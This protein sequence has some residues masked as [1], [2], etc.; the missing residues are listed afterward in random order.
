MDALDETVECRAENAE[1]VV[2]HNAQAFGQVAF[3]V[4]NVGHGA[5]HDVQRLDQQ[6]NQHAQ[7][8]DDYR[9]RNNGRNDCRGAELAELREGFVF[10]HRKP[11]VPVDRRQAFDGGE[12]DDAGFAI[13]LGFTEFAADAGG[14]VR[15][16][17][18]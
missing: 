17:L 12:R 18:G 3:A 4:G 11:D 16:S 5:G 2:V 9:Y 15:V 13:D 6:T 10:I 7:Q 8:C 14:V 1:F